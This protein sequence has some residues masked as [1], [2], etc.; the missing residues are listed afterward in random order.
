MSLANGLFAPTTIISRTTMNP[1]KTHSE[2]FTPFLA[3][4]PGVADESV[5]SSSS[6]PN[7]ESLASPSISN[8]VYTFSAEWL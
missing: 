5:A 3:G 7:F 1:F 6:T 2:T 4:V 8:K